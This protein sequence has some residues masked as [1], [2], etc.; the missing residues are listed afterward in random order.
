MNNSEC[1]YLLWSSFFLPFHLPSFRS[2]SFSILFL[3]S[4]LSLKSEMS[5]IPETKIRTIGDNFHCSDLKSEQLGRWKYHGYFVS[6]FVGPI[7]GQFQGSCIIC[8]SSLIEEWLNHWVSWSTLTHNLPNLTQN[9]PN[10]TQNWTNLTQNWPTLTHSHQT[11]RCPSFLFSIH[12]FQTEI[13]SAT[14]HGRPCFAPGQQHWLRK[15][16]L[17]I[18][19]KLVCFIYK[20]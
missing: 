3:K 16:C 17:R 11:P 6:V 19:Y 20:V 14:T 4:L 8:Q 9:L 10:L 13:A 1:H 15:L 12:V 5:Q 18:G 7:I 2:T